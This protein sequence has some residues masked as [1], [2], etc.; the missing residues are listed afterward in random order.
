MDYELQ[1]ILIDAHQTS[2]HASQIR[3]FLL[4]VLQ[5][6]IDGKEKFNDEI[7]QEAAELIDDIG[8]G[9]FYWMTDIAVQMTLVAQCA[10]RDVPTNVEAELGKDASAEEIIKSVVRV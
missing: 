8:P 10:L 6:D 1:K 9:A 5:E 2:E 3:D 7:L 4:K